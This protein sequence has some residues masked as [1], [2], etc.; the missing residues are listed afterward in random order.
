MSPT[1]NF[2]APHAWGSHLMVRITCQFIGSRT[3]W[4]KRFTVSSLCFRIRIEL[5]TVNKRVRSEFLPARPSY[6]RTI[7]PSTNETMQAYCSRLARRSRALDFL[8]P[9]SF[10]PGIC[11][12]RVTEGDGDALI[13][14]PHGNTTKTTQ[15]NKPTT[16]CICNR[17]SHNS[18]S[19]VNQR[20][21]AFLFTKRHCRSI[22]RLA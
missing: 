12:G 18:V 4:R 8:S 13:W 9:P 21:D 20:I 16:V 14:R 15:T 5:I 2:N 7:S 10:H 19:P 6:H 3:K 17:I 22:H 11:R 1:S